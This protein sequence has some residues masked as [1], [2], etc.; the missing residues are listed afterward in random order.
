MVQRT[1]DTL[2]SLFLIGL[3]LSP[4]TAKNLNGFSLEESRVD[5]D[6]ILRGGPP[7]DGIPALSHPTFIEAGDTTLLE[8]DDRILG[9]AIGGDAR[10]YPVKI[11]NWHEVVND[12]LAGT[13]LVITYCP[14]CG[15]GMAFSRIVDTQELTFGVSGLLYNSDVLLYDHQNESLWSQIMGRAVTGHSAGTRLEQLPLQHTSWQNWR[16]QYPQTLVLSEDTG[17]IRDYTHNPYG[18][19]A[20][21]ERLYFPVENQPE[22]ELHLKET[23]IGVSIAGNHKAYP[24][25]RLERAGQKRFDD[26]I[27]GVP[28]TILWD[29]EA[30]SAMALDENN[31]V[32]PTIQGFW[33]AWYAFHPDT[34][35]YAQP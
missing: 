4:A 8:E 11:L 23:V 9:I 17:Y 5:V 30:S 19:Y 34:E 28:L 35:V 14:L 2:I 15:T 32:L 21:S 10:A 7:R 16:R 18:D 24:F 1:R 13:P 26:T 12:S 29:Q 31:T 22:G 33:F 20:L 3:W 27:G 6:Q 25:S